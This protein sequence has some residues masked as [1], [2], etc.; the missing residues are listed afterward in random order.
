MCLGK[1]DMN[2]RKKPVLHMED[3]KT[4]EGKPTALVHTTTANKSFIRMHSLLKS[5]GIKNNLFH[6]CLLDPELLN[7]NPLTLDS[8]NDPDGKIRAKVAIECMHNPWYFFREI[9][10]IPIQGGTPVLFELHRGNLA[11][12]WCFLSDIDIILTLPRQCGKSICAIAV[13]CYI[14]YIAGYHMNIGMLTLSNTLMQEN[15][16]RL[17]DMR[18]SLPKY[19]FHP[20]AKDGD[21]K[22]GLY[23]AGLKN[24]YLT[25]I[26][27]K[28]KNDASNV[29]RGST[30]PF[31]HIDEGPFIPNIDISYPVIMATTNAARESAKKAGKYHAN[32]LT[33]TAGD[34]STEE[35]RWFK[36]TRIDNAMIFTEKLYDT[37]DKDDAHQMV[38]NNSRSSVE[39][40]GVSAT[41]VSVYAV[42]SYLQ[43][44]KDKAWL[45]DQISR[46][47]CSKSQIDRDYL[48]KWVSHADNPILSKAITD[49]M[50]NYRKDEPDYVEVWGEYVVKWYVPADEVKSGLWK[51]KPI[52]MGCDISE[53]IG[54]DFTTTVGV[55]PETLKVVCTFGCNISNIAKFS[56]FISDFLLEYKKCLWVPERKSQASAIIDT[57][58]LRLR[59]AGHNPFRRIFNKIVDNK[60][61][62]EYARYDIDNPYL[63]DQAN[64]R[65]VLG[66]MTT[67]QSRPF[68]YKQILQ[69]ASEVA[70]D[71]IYDP[72]LIGELVSLQARNGR[73]DHSSAGHDDHCM[74]WL[75]AMYVIFEGKNLSAYGIDPLTILREVKSEKKNHKLYFSQQ[76]QLRT[77]ILERLETI[78]RTSNQLSKRL[79]IYDLEREVEKL[80][81]SL[82]INPI[83]V[84]SLKE[85]SFDKEAIL[86]Q[87]RDLKR[88]EKPDGLY[89]NL[90]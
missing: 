15:V 39:A 86:K 29:G 47:G 56:T 42:F 81:D 71:K 87:F 30:L 75:L 6:L 84:D 46:G 72:A 80:D 55:D 60:H 19:L 14:L 67:G 85:E 70:A 79:L 50:Y 69:R 8:T 22:E 53:L 51:N 57:T 1:S 90:F 13:C 11:L 23:Y 65:K 32:M 43:L 82:S 76:Q 7:V 5:M 62:E 35:G 37:Q 54:N 36:M 73:I 40:G 59:S 83:N 52:I 74:A 31:L 28:S 78:K 12:L 34:P 25:F 89:S 10:R 4:I 66:F 27:Q 63:S 2:G 26:G 21:N 24:K 48:N 3:W 18:D 17:K 45:A 58:I 61:L 44:G 20:S 77:Y 49:T 41:A 68:L 33:T 16:K 38:R 64:A 9:C 88:E